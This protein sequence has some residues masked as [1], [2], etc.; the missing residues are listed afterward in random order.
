MRPL[1]LATSR[2]VQCATG[3]ILRSGE[4]NS[5]MDSV[6]YLV[7]RYPEATLTAIRREIE[8]VTSAGCPVSRFAHRPSIQPLLSAVDRAEARRDRVSGTGGPLAVVAGVLRAFV[9]RPLRFIKALRIAVSIE[10]SAMRA[11]SYLAL[12]CMLRNAARGTADCDPACSFWLVV[13][14]RRAPD[15]RTRGPSVVRHSPWARRI[16]TQQPQATCAS[17]PVCHA[18]RGNQPVGRFRAAGC[19]FAGPHRAAGGRL[20]C[21][22]H[23]SHADHGQST[24][25]RRIVCIARLDARKGHGVLLKALSLLDGM[26]NQARVELIGDGPCREEIESDS[27]SEDLSDQ[28]RNQ[29]MARGSGC[30]GCT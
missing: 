26:R 15:S 12:A 14:R 28:G 29:G 24:R 21:R 16:R 17:R 9:T 6:A 22:K 2:G 27:C 8:A 30:Q 25:K 1:M 18:H 7:N 11:L 4:L 20:G 3:H 19:C 23:F 5:T 10:S 13:S